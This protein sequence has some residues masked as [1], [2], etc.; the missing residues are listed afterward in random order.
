MVRCLL[1]FEPCD[2]FQRLAVYSAGSNREVHIRPS[3]IPPHRGLELRLSWRKVGGKIG[4]QSPDQ[5]D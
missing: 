1:E 2:C 3:T 4:L 5:A